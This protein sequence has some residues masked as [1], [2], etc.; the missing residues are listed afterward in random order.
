[1]DT[2]SRA[3]A[4]KSYTPSRTGLQRDMISDWEEEQERES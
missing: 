4:A 2:R 3:K 1:M